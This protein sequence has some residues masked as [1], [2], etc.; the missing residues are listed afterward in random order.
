[1]PNHAP[2]RQ[3][4]CYE[5]TTPG[6]TAWGGIQ[7]VTDWLKIYEN[8]TRGMPANKG[9]R[10]LEIGRLRH[11]NNLRLFE[12]RYLSQLWKQPIGLFGAVKFIFRPIEPVYPLVAEESGE[13]PPQPPLILGE[14][15]DETVSSQL[16]QRA[17]EQQ[18]SL[19]AWVLAELYRYLERCRGEF[20]SSVGP[21]WLRIL[22]PMNVR[23]ISDRRMPAANRTAIVQIDRRSNQLGDLRALAVDLNRE[24]EIIRSWHLYKL[25]L[26]AVRG[27]SCLP[28]WLARSARSDKCRGVAIFTNLSDPFRRPLFRVDREGVDLGNARLESFDFVGPVRRGA[29]MYVCLQK[30]AGRLRI[31]IHVD[32]RIMTVSQAR[33]WLEGWIRHLVQG[34]ANQV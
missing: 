22:L 5:N 16:K 18:V 3:N 21:T 12:K 23:D 20:H 33:G 8:L 11:R 1:M 27:M 2:A 32:R 25:F 29:P 15:L 6:A 4:S 7:L 26:L 30:Q 34:A 17:V 9:L 31:S 28:G 24:I 14:W 10:S 19:N 13:S